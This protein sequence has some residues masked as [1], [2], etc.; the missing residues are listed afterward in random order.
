MSET[1]ALAA[2]VLVT[3]ATIKKLQ[4]DILANIAPYLQQELELILQCA[5]VTNAIKVTDAASLADADEWT[6]VLLRRNDEIE[7][8]RQSGPG[9]FNKLGRALGK[10]FKP[11][12]DAIGAAVS[13]LKRERGEYLLGEQ[14]KQAAAYQAAAVAHM[15]G[16]HD[17]AQSALVVANEAVTLA[18]KGTSVREVWAV[19]RY[20]PSLMV[21]STP[22][23]PGLV[24]D[25]QAIRAYL[26]KLPI[27]EDPALPGVIC[28]KI[29]HVTD[30]R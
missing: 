16:D 27:D 20:E 11:L 24:P 5:E 7:A 8:V 23:H 6:K 22:E 13:N 19:E 2:P 29:P 14:K 4:D 15:A 17:E 10:P 21:V 3:D 28:K 1:N 18:P 12:T 9:A 25:E 26:A 30:R